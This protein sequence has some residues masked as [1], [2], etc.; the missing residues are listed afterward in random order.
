M[1][2]LPSQAAF[3]LQAPDRIFDQKNGNIHRF[4]QGDKCERT[5]KDTDG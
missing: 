3:F 2:R 4:T 5:E 1:K